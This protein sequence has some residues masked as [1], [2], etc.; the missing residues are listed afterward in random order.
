MT[1]TC[2]GLE[3]VRVVLQVVVALVVVGALAERAAFGVCHKIL[4]QRLLQAQDGGSRLLLRVKPD[5]QPKLALRRDEK[6]AAG[7]DRR[8][9]S[10]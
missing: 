1:P 3:K 7:G 9:R 4:L 10:P 8:L 2:D 6:R 5:T